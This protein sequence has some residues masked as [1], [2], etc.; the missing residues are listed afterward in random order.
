MVSCNFAIHQS[1]QSINL[2]HNIIEFIYVHWIAIGN[3]LFLHRPRPGCMVIG[4]IEM[5]GHRL[6]KVVLEISQEGDPCTLSSACSRVH[7][8]CRVKDVSLYST[9][10][11]TSND[12][13]IMD[14]SCHV[15]LLEGFKNK[16]HW[17]I[18]KH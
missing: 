15:N 9:I 12:E 4:G 3:G 14:T 6:T 5:T 11:F 2:V 7:S 16:V 10:W 1:V 13:W 18:Q 8:R 17:V